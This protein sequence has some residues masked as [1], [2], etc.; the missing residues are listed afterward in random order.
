MKVII[1]FLALSV[2]LISSV[3]AYD[4]YANPIQNKIEAGVVK[5]GDRVNLIPDIF[6]QDAK[7]EDVDRRLQKEKVENITG[8]VS[9]IKFEDYIGKNQF[10]YVRKSFSLVCNIK[11]YVLLVFD[12][13]LNLQKAKGTRYEH[14]CL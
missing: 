4:A 11:T 1:Y 7:F 6:L 2:A 10:I 14:G 3:I 12:E 9:G 8:N 5:W 13:D